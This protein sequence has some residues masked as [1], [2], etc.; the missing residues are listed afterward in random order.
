MAARPP[1][2]D[3]L[4][5]QIR[6]NNPRIIHNPAPQVTWIPNGPNYKDPSIT[7]ERAIFFNN[8]LHLVRVF[9]AAIERGPEENF[10][11][12][13]SSG[14][15][16]EP[17]LPR[18]TSAREPMSSASP[19]RRAASPPTGNEENPQGALSRSSN[20]PRGA[21]SGNP[22][23]SQGT[24]SG[25]SAPM[26]SESPKNP[27]NGPQ[28]RSTQP[29][30]GPSLSQPANQQSQTSFSH[31]GAVFSSWQQKEI[32]KQV[33][34][35]S[36]LLAGREKK[37]TS[38]EK[39]SFKPLETMKTIQNLE[40]LE[41]NLRNLEEQVKEGNK[42]PSS[43]QA[44]KNIQNTLNQSKKELQDLASQFKEA[45]LHAKEEIPP[46]TPLEKQIAMLR[47]KTEQVLTYARQSL[48]EAA[49]RFNEQNNTP[50][51]PQ[52][53]E[54]FA[55]QRDQ[56]EA[57]L[58]NPSSSESSQAK[59]GKSSKQADGA[60][61]AL[62]PE[63]AKGK[64]VPNARIKTQNEPLMPS[65]QGSKT[66]MKEEKA[67]LIKNASDLQNLVKKAEK[68]ELKLP[69]ALA[70][71]YPMATKKRPERMA[72]GI[73]KENVQSNRTP[74]KD[75]PEEKKKKQ[76]S[77]SL[78]N[79]TEEDLYIQPMVFIPE[80]NTIIGDP[81]Y[82]KV[83]GEMS[84]KI[85]HIP[86]FLIATTSIIN[87]QFAQWLNDAWEEET[88]QLTEQ[89]VVVDLQGNIL[90]KT[91]MADK[92][93]SIHVIV[94]KDKVSFSPLEDQEYYPVVQVSWHGA[95]AYCETYGLRL[96]NEQERETAAG[97]DLPGEHQSMKKFRYGCKSN[98]I[99]PSLANY[100][101]ASFLESEIQILPVAYFDGS[102][103]ITRGGVQY[104]TENAQSPYGCY[105]MSGNVYEW[106]SDGSKDKKIVKGGSF[107]SS[108][109]SLRVS[110]RKS[111]PP[112]TCL[113]D[114]SFRCALDVY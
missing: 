105:D 72:I 7:R 66:E 110:A 95:C 28:L 101:D 98:E 93:S 24:S 17:Q 46:H 10:I 5:P 40:T 74:D 76:E 79:G 26:A 107:L 35:A 21:S 52:K 61:A 63:T 32:I 14:N 94:H 71:I 59:E 109:E 113:P 60:S 51:S 15:T 90:F 92:T 70:V 81:F 56:R 112:D 100:R 78:E 88:I 108:P 1:G 34:V 69:A 54:A 48:Q 37:E 6:T 50:S 19:E 82:D 111:L 102:H 2:S 84:G 13:E 42:N 27:T 77:Q 31:P 18:E 65:L 103:S 97:M 75:L 106:I 57:S 38:E 39:S 8:I 99:D 80:R 67:S 4:I 23:P 87:L 83:K 25:S 43:N 30:K 86:P 85:V 96:P 29:G 62:N 9:Q 16:Q 11:Y 104:P 73:E 41:E 3:P 114:V 89:G 64:E 33:A 45:A 58:K 20:P 68:K 22:A 44:G 47:Q 36:Y 91:H 12:Q 49:K 53:Q 55:K